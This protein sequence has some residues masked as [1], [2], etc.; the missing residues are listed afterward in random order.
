[1]GSSDQDI[2]ANLLATF[3][4]QASG[5]RDWTK[6]AQINRDNNLRLQYLAGM[7]FNSYLST[8]ILQSILS[9]YRFPE[10]LFVGSGQNINFLKESLRN[11]GR[12]EK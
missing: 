11:Q 2:A 9:Y 12:R 4:G 3:A 8:K 7:Y 6:N 10:D 5:L 1:M